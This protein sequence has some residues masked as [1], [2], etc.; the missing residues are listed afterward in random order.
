MT[1]SWMSVAACGLLCAQDQSD[2]PSRVARLNYLGGSVSF[3]PDN[4]QEWTAATVNY[5]LTTGD[6]LWTDRDSRADMHIGSSVVH[7]ADQTAFAILNLDDR[8]AQISLTQGAVNVKIER[9]Q[10]D[11]TFEVDTPNGAIVL[12]R[13]GDYRIDVNG[14]ANSTALIVRAG[15][16][17][18]T[19]GGQAMPVHA[20]QML[21][22]SGTDQLR[23]ETLQIP[24]SDQFDQWCM[25][26][27]RREERAIQASANYVPAEMIGAGDLADNGVW[28]NDPGYGAV[29]APSRMPMGW[30]PY[31]Y[32]HWAFVSPWGWTWIDDAPWGFA[33]F[34]YGRWAV[35][36]GGWVWVPGS[37]VARP[38][39]APA[40][41][42]F[43]G[44]SRFSLAVGIGGGG[45]VAW[46]PLGPREVYRPGYRVSDAYV[47]RVNVT[48]VTNITNVNVT[49]VTYVN[50]SHVTVVPQG[51][52]TGARPVAAAAVRVPPQAM[53]QAQA[54][55][56]MDVR[57]ARESFMG[58]P[59]QPGVRFGAP[60]AQVAARQVVVKQAPPASV[61]PMGGV[62]VA[63]PVR[64]NPTPNN[65]PNNTP[66]RNQPP[67]PMTPNR[68]QVNTGAPQ[69]N[70][71][72][73]PENSRPRNDRPPSFS[74]GRPPMNNTPN[75]PANSVQ[76]VTPNRAPANVSPQPERQQ[77]PP[78][79]RQQQQPER[80]QP[81][82]QVRQQQQP[83]RQQPP[84]QVRQQQQP[85][86]QQPPPQVRQQQQPE[87]QQPPPQVRQ[88]PQADRQQPPPQVR[89]QAQPERQQ[90]PPQVRQQQQPER[91]QPPPQVRQQP[92]QQPQAQRQQP[93]PDR[94]QQQNNQRQKNDK[95]KDA[96]DEKK[97]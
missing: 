32:G 47:R 93:P 3:R 2:P 96:R 14:E 5:P 20:R 69:V 73:Q 12:L 81:P 34:H 79:V 71:A 39:Y 95:P 16:A 23:T 77:P 37:M 67:P 41:V 72:P 85:E 10:S 36:G 66:A 15:D 30:E 4:V 44:G 19:G 97:Q 52:F 51:A 49:N 76:P 24:A 91:Q 55:N 13:S 94:Q 18:V 31:R 42:A 9:L 40:L 59:A 22:F 87:R 75:Q 70:N 29:W 53:S 64:S 48:N 80:Q 27:D 8:M 82:P 61:R 35:L 90:P 86:R 78:Q 54:V 46:I 45:G 50:Q 58:R 43:V 68:P 84:P 21:R 7:L 83:E 63:E 6:H 25:D 88:Q 1:W 57:P 28:R 74:N 89:Q 65:M 26:R 92:Q 38:V 17:E 62:R 60:P 56:A 11:E 33:P